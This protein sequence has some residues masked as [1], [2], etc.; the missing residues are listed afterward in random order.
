MVKQSGKADI[1][2][3]AIARALTRAARRHRAAIATEL[4]GL[5]LFPGQE[6]VVRFL[7]GR[8]SASMS[9]IAADLNVRPPTASKMIARLVTQGFLERQ[10][11]RQDQRMI[12]VRLTPAGRERAAG[13]D[14]ALGKAE[15]RM[16]VGF[17]DKDLR[18]LRK[19][20]KRLARN[21]GEN[22]DE[23]HDETDE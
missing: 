22:E 1:P 3:D 19:L 21:L 5:G 15:A 23:P 6:Q 20:L 16:T 2:A 12:A 14:I 11:S 4:A 13:V 17:D 7:A 18:R 10:E 8:E 9:E